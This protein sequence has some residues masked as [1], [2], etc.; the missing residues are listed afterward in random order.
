M[1][2]RSTP[3]LSYVG[4]RRRIPCNKSY[5]CISLVL[6]VVESNN[7]LGMWNNRG[8]A[9]LICLQSVER[10]AGT[11]SVTARYLILQRLLSIENNIFRNCV[12]GTV[13]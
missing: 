13:P 4:A 10:A 9:E 11:A 12:L 3:L 2:D 8:F 1:R 5:G 6:H 7:S